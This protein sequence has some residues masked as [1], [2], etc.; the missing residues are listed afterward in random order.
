ME[1]IKITTP[2]I[3]LGQLLKLTNKFES[4]GMIKGY[5]AEKGAFVNGELDKRRGRKVYLKDIV[6]LTTGETYIVKG[7]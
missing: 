1:E 5:L 2:F 6:K 4:G 7:K 3:T